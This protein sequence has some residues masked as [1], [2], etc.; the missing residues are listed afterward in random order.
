[1]ITTGLLASFCSFSV[2]FIDDI[3]KEPCIFVANHKSILDP[4]ALIDALD[5][6]VFFLA[7][8]D[9]YKIPILNLILNTLETIPIKKNSADVSALKKAIK[10]L[11]DGRSIAL[12][13]E[14]GI[15][16][17]KGVK[18]IYKGAMYLSYKSG[19]PIVPVGISGTDV[20]LPMGEYLPHS[21][22]IS[23][24]VG[25]S[26]YPDLSLKKAELLEN[27]KNAVVNALNELTNFHSK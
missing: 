15:S 18:K 7:S 13:P 2:K 25:K 27:M 10:M 11:D 12:F 24:T 3:P 6:R 22:K 9:L 8:K 26:I 17:S 5:R 16:L 20:V 1:M 23:V 21:G 19:F 4:I 14:G